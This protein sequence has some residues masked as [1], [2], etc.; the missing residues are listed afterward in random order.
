[1]LA[2][3]IL[4][5]QGYLLVDIKGY[6]L[7][8]F[9]DRLVAQ[10][11]VLYKVKH[12]DR[13][14]LRVKMKAVDFFR[15]RKLI[16]NRLCRAKIIKKNGAPFIWHNIKQR[17][18]LVLAFLLFVSIFYFSSLFVWSITID[19][20][21]N[22]DK[23]EIYNLLQSYNVERGS[24]KKNLDLDYLERNIMD[25]IQ[26]ISWVNLQWRGTNLFLE[27]VEKIE[28][29][30]E[31]PARITAARDGVVTQL[32]VLKGRAVVEE[33]M[34]VISGQTLV[35]PEFEGQKVRAIVRALVWYNASGHQRIEKRIP[36]LTG[37]KKSQWTIRLGDKQI[38]PS[39]GKADYERYAY[40]STVR[41]FPGSK[42]INYDLQ[43]IRENYLELDFAKLELS[44]QQAFFVARDRALRSLL[45]QVSQRAEI[46]EIK[47][48]KKLLRQ[49]QKR[50]ARVDIL[51]KLQ[52]DIAVLETNN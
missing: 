26:G 20:P 48:K 2:G 45:A 18:S 16:R 23:N 13:Y 50:W 4:F 46:V 42:K 30:K 17:P 15:L 37:N 9:L 22:I 51:M 29:N 40:Y 39:F 19:G 1:M 31:P 28:A 5:F 24:F 12:I 38:T 34:T 27:V 44:N 21:V 49:N 47:E 52:E 14:H 43:L 11:L 32:I 6:A 10:G 3:I 7:E 25:E 36:Y 8:R 33:G 35:V 41:N